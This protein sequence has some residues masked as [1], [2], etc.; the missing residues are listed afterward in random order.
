MLKPFKSA[1]S[2]LGVANGILYLFGRAMQ[3]LSKGRCY[4]IRYYLVAQPVPNPFVP[5]C[6]PSE[7]DKIVEASSHDSLVEHFPRPDF[8][9]RERFAKGH[10][11]LAATH[12]NVFSGFL[13]FARGSYDEDEVHCRFLLAE[14]ATTAW[15]FDVH[16]EPRFRLGRTFAR[17]W[18][19]A[20]ERYSASGIKWSISRISAFNQ[21]SLQ[22]HG[23]MGI[24]RLHTLTFFCLGKLQVG[25]MSCNPYLSLAWREKNRPT[26][27]IYPPDSGN[28]KFNLVQ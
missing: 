2:S 27:T 18:D 16:V 21:Q 17:L 13:W 5:V 28:S 1:I 23:R 7:S 3:A 22:S 8:V 25:F 26:V 15:D 10:V 20:N 12:K 4:L 19:G 24:R 14:P 6:R 11:C 9:I